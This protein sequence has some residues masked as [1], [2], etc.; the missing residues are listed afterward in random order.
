VEHG[1]IFKGWWE[2][3]NVFFPFL[4]LVD[5]RPAGFCFVIALPRAEKSIE[6]RLNDFFLLHPYRG[7]GIGEIAASQILDR[8]QGQWDV[9]VIPSNKRAQAFWRKMIAA[10]TSG[11]FQEEIRS[12]VGEG[13][14]AIFSF[15][16]KSQS[17][18]QPQNQKT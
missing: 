2:K 12:V 6:F 15:N 5:G 8:F 1:E 11:Q 13:D 10:Y 7:K 3:P 17:K 18:K 9:H 14:M 4:I 16:N